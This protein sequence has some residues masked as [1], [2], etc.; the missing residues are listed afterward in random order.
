MLSTCFRKSLFWRIALSLKGPTST[1]Y[2]TAIRG[3]GSANVI[4]KTR[5]SAKFY[6]PRIPLVWSPVASKSWLMS[7]LCAMPK[8]E[9]EPMR[10]SPKREEGRGVRSTFL[11]TRSRRFPTF[12][13]TRCAKPRIRSSEPRLG[14]HRA[15]PNRNT[16]FHQRTHLGSSTIRLI[17]KDQQRSS[18]YQ[19]GSVVLLE[20]LRRA[21]G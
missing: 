17:H 21:I 13:I 10:K 18:C 12:P 6:P 3:Q 19:V 14:V 7:D 5:P 9:N 11:I 8:P 4:P 20:S 1:I 15:N 16:N 2:A